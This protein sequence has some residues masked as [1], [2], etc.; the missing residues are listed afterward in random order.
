MLSNVNVNFGGNLCA[1]AEFKDIGSDKVANFRVAVNV[2]GKAEKTEY[3][4]CS[5]FGKRA[6]SMQRIGALRKGDTVFINGSLTT[7]EY[8]GKN[9]KGTSLDVRVAD[10]AL[11]GSKSGPAPAAADDASFPE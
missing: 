11:A 6:E 3:I 1:D 7:R 10:V 8:E 9:G 2:P 5:L 4:S